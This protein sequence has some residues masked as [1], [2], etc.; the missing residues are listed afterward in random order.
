MAGTND[1]K[2]G[3]VKFEPDLLL[4]HKRYN[5]PSYHNDIGL[6]RLKERMKFSDRVKAIDFTEHEVPANAT[7]TLT[8]WGRLSVRLLLSVS[9][10]YFNYDM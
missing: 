10:S 8:G 4:I 1:L 5:R 7:V 2:S 3:G 9:V 6:V